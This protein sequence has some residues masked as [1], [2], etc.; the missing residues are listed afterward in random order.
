MSSATTLQEEQQ[1]Q[2]EKDKKNQN[3][4]EQAIILA[5]LLE[6]A[7]L[8]G[9]VEEAGRVAAELAR[10]NSEIKSKCSFSLDLRSCT[11]R[12][13]DEAERQNYQNQR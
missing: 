2:R 8:Q 3:E 13:Q 11:V 7:I 4:H 5:T 10:A 9:D 12:A 1:R 6:R